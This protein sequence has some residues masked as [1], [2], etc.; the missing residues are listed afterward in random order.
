M[1]RIYDTIVAVKTE[2]RF[3]KNL[4]KTE[5]VQPLMNVARRYSTTPE[6]ATFAA[7]FV[8]LLAAR[9]GL[10]FPLPDLEVIVKGAPKLPD[11]VRKFIAE[12]IGGHWSEYQLAVGSFDEEDLADFFAAEAMCL[13]MEARE[14]SSVHP[15]IDTL[16]T[17]LLDI[18]RGDEVADL[19]CGI[20][21]FVQKSW[22]AL[23]N[24]TGSDKGLSVTGYSPNATYAAISWIACNVA[25][26]NAQ[27]IHENMFSPTNAR[28]DK[29]LVIPP[30]G[31]E[32]RQL[33]ILEVS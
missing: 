24:V 12:T 18:T 25:E 31:F 29:V 1:T 19:N 32:A 30:F 3:M 33:N 27:I 23:W 7:A 5:M 17:G 16:C 4:L 13:L 9:Q 11:Y 14:D 20:G 8:V 28:Y 2:S 10:K 26:V 6:Y 21:K 22:F 15:V